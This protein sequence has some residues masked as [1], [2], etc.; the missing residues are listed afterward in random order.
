MPKKFAWSYSALSAFET[1]PRKYWHERIGRTVKEKKSSVA[2]YGTMAHR[3]FELRLLKG[4]KLPLDLK[5]H[6]PT[7]AKL[8]NASGEG[9]PE[10]KLAIND[11]FQPTGFFDDD[12]WCRAIIDY[13]KHNGRHILI[14]DHKFGKMKSNFDQLDLMAAMIVCH[15]EEIETVT[16]AFYW[17]KEK[18]IAP[19]KYV[20]EDMPEVWASFLPRVQAMQDAITNEDFPA[21]PSGLCKNYCLVKS[22]PHCGA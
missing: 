21:R 3:K 5:H 11:R 4:Q 19:K 14:V 6:E 1:C 7:L 2:D 17:A 20:R 10:Q 8:A 15:I 12:V 9:M 13:A 22:C 18:K 16:G